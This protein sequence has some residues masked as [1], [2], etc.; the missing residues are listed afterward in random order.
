MVLSGNGE[1]LDSPNGSIG[2][3][4]ALIESTDWE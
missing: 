2:K 1:K 4:V 3:T